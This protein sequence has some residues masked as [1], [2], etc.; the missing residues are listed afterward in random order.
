M[1]N[2]ARGYSNKWLTWSQSGSTAPWW[3]HNYSGMTVEK[4]FVKHHIKYA[5]K[6]EKKNQWQFLLTPPCIKLVIRLLIEG[7]SQR[8]W[9]AAGCTV[10]CPLDLPK[11]VESDRQTSNRTKNRRG[12]QHY[13]VLVGDEGP[14]HPYSS[15][16][17]C[18]QVWAVDREVTEHPP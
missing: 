11:C 4:T 12:C 9:K 6:E 17:R 5:R 14:C 7:Y 15:H 18:H 10:S 13:K 1:L 8:S 2:I 16:C 3:C